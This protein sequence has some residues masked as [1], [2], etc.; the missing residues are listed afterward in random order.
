LAATYSWS[1]TTAPQTSFWAPTV[2]PQT[3][4]TDTNS[5]E[6][7]V[8]FYSSVTGYLTGIRFYKGSGNTGT[9]VGNL[10]TTGG[11]LLATATFTGETASGWQ[12]VNFA[13]PVA[14]SANT[15]YIASYFAPNGHYAVDAGFF[16][17]SALDASPLH[18]PSSPSSGGN[19]VYAYGTSS[20][21]P[22]QSYNGSNYWVDVVFST[23]PTVLST[24]PAAGATGVSRTT[25]ITVAFD[26]AMDPTTING[27]T[28]FLKDSSGNVVAATVT[29]NAATNTATLTPSATLNL[30]ATYN[31]WLLGGASGPRVR[32]QYGNYL[33]SNVTWSFTTGNT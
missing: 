9:H 20:S 7:G 16:D 25:A 23:P 2:T 32:D 21:F 33:A 24:T 22:G 12:Q 3:I 8:K 6:L 10:W 17:S 13:S 30:A 11:Q 27:S 29:Y 14:I 5:V 4:S 15:T 26:R 18:A 28:F 19:G 31:V 1:F